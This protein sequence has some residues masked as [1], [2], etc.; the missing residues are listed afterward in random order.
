MGLNIWIW[1]S[2]VKI[3]EKMQEHSKKALLL[4]SDTN[5]FVDFIRWCGLHHMS[6]APV[7]VF[8][9]IFMIPHMLMDLKIAIMS[10]LGWFILM[11]FD[12]KTALVSH[13]ARMELR[14]N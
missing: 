6:H 5:L 10:V 14:L 7:M 8:L 11:G 2:Y 3:P 9:H 13:K 12:I 1:R 4:M